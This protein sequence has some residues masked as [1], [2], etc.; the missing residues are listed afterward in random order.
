MEIMDGLNACEY[1]TWAD[2]HDIDLTFTYLQSDIDSCNALA[3]SYYN[4]VLDVDESLNYLA[5][6]QFLRKLLDQLKTLTGNLNFKETFFFQNYRQRND[7]AHTL[8]ATLGAAAD[9][10]RFYFYVTE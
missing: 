7:E 8:D 2:Y 6:N 4:F 3:I 10:P 5:A 1:L 9:Q